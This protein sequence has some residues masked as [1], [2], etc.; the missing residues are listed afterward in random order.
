MN[1]SRKS[2][3]RLTK[4]RDEVK[5]LNRKEIPASGIY[6]AGGKR[7]DRPPVNVFQPFQK[8]AILVDWE[9]VRKSLFHKAPFVDYND[10]RNLLR[11]FRALL[12]PDEVL[13]RIF[14]Y[15]SSPLKPRSSIPEELKK[16]WEAGYRK[17]SAFLERISVCENIALRKGFLRFKGIGVDDATGKKRLIF[18]Q[19]QV[20]MLIGLDIAHLSFNR[21]VD[22][23]LLF[24]ADTD[25]I[26]A[27]KT[28]RKNGL[29]VVIPVFE[30]VPG[31]KVSRKIKEHADFLRRRNFRRIFGLEENQ[32]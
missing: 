7:N 5:D 27:M 11:L 32:T 10:P 16:E 20:D 29:Q 25:L 3:D 18:E 15:V 22:R 1:A 4:E 26:P 6:P 17:H 12:E 24:T 23:I 21:L 30:D 28:A 14:L 8:L 13:Y 19:K 9:N 2:D 31:Y